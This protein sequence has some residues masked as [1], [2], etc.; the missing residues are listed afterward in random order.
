MNIEN[1]TQQTPPTLNETY[2]QSNNNPKSF[3]VIILAILLLITLFIFGAYIYFK[4]IYEPESVNLSTNDTTSANPTQPQPTIIEY[5][6]NSP[7]AVPTE[8]ITVDV[9]GVDN[10]V[11]L[12][13]YE[14]TKPVSAKWSVKP[15]LASY[16]KSNSG[17]IEGEKFTLII[18]EE[19]EDEAYGGTGYIGEYSWFET[20]NYGQVYRVQIDD[21]TTGRGDDTYTYVHGN[22]FKTIGTCEGPYSLQTGI[23]EQAP[24]GDSMLHLPNVALL[25]VYC[26]AENEAGLTECD[27][28]VASLKKL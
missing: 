8:K 19:Y 26:T 23:V 17:F 11:R 16:T 28:I 22:N 5:I 15:D 12:K 20:Q 25:S 9:P 27:K 18:K 14:L 3:A 21:I 24:C 13:K 7:T 6:T 2:V 1:N 4:E 10:S